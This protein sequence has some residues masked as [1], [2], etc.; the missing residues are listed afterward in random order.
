MSRKT[1]AKCLTEAREHI[2]NAR[3]DAAVITLCR[4]IE[5]LLQ[6]LYV[7]LT[8]RLDIEDPAQAEAL[9]ELY[10]DFVQDELGDVTLTFDEWID[11]Y[12]QADLCAQLAAV[13]GY[14]LNIFSQA[15][16]FRIRELRNKCGHSDSQ[17]THDEAFEVR[18]LLANFLAETTAEPASPSSS[19]PPP[20]P[21]GEW[22]SDWQ[23]KWGSVIKKWLQS[24]SGSLE[25]ALVSLLL[26]Q[27]MLLVGLIADRRIPREIKPQLSM[28][29]DYVLDPDDY[30]SEELEGVHGLIDDAAVLALTLYW[31]SRR[32]DV[33]ETILREHWTQASSPLETI[34][35]LYLLLHSN[36]AALFSD[37]IWAAIAPIAENG[38]QALPTDRHAAPA[39]DDRADDDDPADYAEY[40]VYRLFSDDADAASTDTTWSAHWRERI[41]AWAQNNPQTKLASLLQLLPQAF[42]FLSRLLRDPRLSDAV[43][44]RLLALTNYIATPY[45]LIP[46]ALVGVAGL[47]DDVAAFALVGYWLVNLAKVDKALLREHWHGGDDPAAV[48]NPLHQQI[49]ENADAIFG[50]ESGIW[51]TLQEKFEHKAD[52]SPLA[53]LRGIFD[54]GA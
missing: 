15:S 23:Q 43:K 14:Q 42:D 3:Y 30:I 2:Q 16:L 33:D 40:N 45:D 44:T 28:A 9:Q 53:K 7:G 13:F 22:L 48:I 24:P 54:R 19:A 47:T 32:D 1:Y 12:D 18:N 8:E 27:L 51:Q 20:G 29:L 52:L 11:F 38:P 37:R 25:A 10:D 31:L 41:D 35:A 49:T 6:T 26:D 17:P 4:C 5:Q 21:A 39:A 50:R 36:H 46:E 34:N